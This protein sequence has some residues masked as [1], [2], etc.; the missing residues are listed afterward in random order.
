MKKTVIKSGSNNM[1]ILACLLI[2]IIII[3]LIS[4][5]FSPYEHILIQLNKL[6]PEFP[7]QFYTQ[8]YHIFVNKVI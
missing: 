3:G 7:F 5:L 4:I 6:R 8:E 1:F 2:V